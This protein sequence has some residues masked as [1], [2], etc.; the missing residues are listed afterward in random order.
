M[1]DGIELGT[2]LFTVVEPAPGQAGAYN[3]WY[4]RDHF[5]AGMMAMPHCFAGRRWVATAA[6][7][8]LTGVERGS[9][10]ATY[11]IE[12]GCHDAFAQ[13]AFDAFARL[14]A[15]GRMFEGR[16]HVHTGFYELDAAV[17]RHADGM[18]PALALDHPFAGVV[19]ALGGAAPPPGDAVALVLTWRPIATPGFEG[20]ADPLHLL[21]LDAAPEECA[22]DWRPAVA[23]ATWARAFI[24][25]VPGT[26]AHLDAL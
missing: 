2:C 20:P 25:T 17:R 4:E 8:A 7:K 15:K 22:G 14:S 1:G 9:F 26:T 3:A 13:A 16:E 11:W 6:L 5:Y 18:P 23:G 10:L 21:F 24:P 12:A 19:A